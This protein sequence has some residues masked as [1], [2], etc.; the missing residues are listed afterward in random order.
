MSVTYGFYNSVNEDRKYDAEQVSSL[1]DG[2]ISDGIYADY[3][4]GLKVAASSGLTVTVD[5]GRGWF[6]HTWIL[7]DSIKT[8]TFAQSSSDKYYVI[9]IKID[10]NARVN[11]IDYVT[12]NSYP[13]SPLGLNSQGIYYYPLAYVYVP[14]RSS[15]ISYIRDR[16]GY[17]ETPW[18]VGL[19]EQVSAENII[20]QWQRQYDAWFVEHQNDF[21]NWSQ[22]QQEEYEEWIREAKNEFLAWA[23][24]VEYEFTNWSEE[25]KELMDQWLNDRKSDFDSWFEHLQNELDDNQAAH[26]QNEIDTLDNKIE[27]TFERRSLIKREGNRIR[28]VEITDQDG[29]ESVCTIFYDDNNV[30]TEVRTVV[31][32]PDGSSY[33]KSVQ[34]NETYSPGNTLIVEEKFPF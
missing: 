34:Y 3:L 22:E 13:P 6:H 9:V 24:Q 2:L 25:E 4:N 16:R 29:N 1:F 8:I 19:V 23:G 21:L 12:F 33:T 18:V 10:T 17:G 30:I 15:T 28:T 32:R 31:T 7:N 20:E 14:A 11:S 27:G 26:L 5:T